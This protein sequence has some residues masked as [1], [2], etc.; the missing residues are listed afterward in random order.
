MAH[1]RHGIRANL[2]ANREQQPRYKQRAANEAF[3]IYRPL[4]EESAEQVWDALADARRDVSRFF[5]RTRGTSAELVIPAEIGAT[6]VMRVKVRR[7]MKHGLLQR[8]FDLNRTLA[9]I[10]EYKE[11]NDSELEVPLSETD[12]FD[13]GERKLVYKFEEATKATHQLAKQSNDIGEIL[14]S[15]KAGELKVYQPDHVTLFKYGRRRDGRDLSRE[16]KN[17]VG[18]IVEE[19]F[20]DANIGAIVL[21]GLVPGDSYSQ[22]RLAA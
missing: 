6:F 20:A 9:V 10:E 21:A 4:A 11:N 2:V 22:P 12:W 13:Q 3:G 5:S 8:G 1:K 14:E 16:H 17:I 18:E 7:A 15:C 19:R